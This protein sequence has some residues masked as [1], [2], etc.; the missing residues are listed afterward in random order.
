MRAARMEETDITC[1]ARATP[2]PFPSVDLFIRH[3]QEGHQIERRRLKRDYFWLCGV[4]L[5]VR[6]SRQPF[7]VISGCRWR[8]RVATISKPLFLGNKNI[9][10][11]SCTVRGLWR[12]VFQKRADSCAPNYN[13]GP[14]FEVALAGRHVNAA[15]GRIRARS[16]DPRDRIRCRPRI[17]D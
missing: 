17:S 10:K 11:T 7:L 15:S 1:K 8:R 3:L 13:F 4:P 6:Q 9:K 2:R 16:H 14:S 12:P 5:V